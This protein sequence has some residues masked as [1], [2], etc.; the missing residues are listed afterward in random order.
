MKYKFL[1]DLTS[2]VLFEA[3]GKDLKEV[4]ENSALAMLTIIC[5]VK[6]IEK[7][8]KIEIEVSGRDEKDLL[9]NWLQELI[10]QVDIEEMFFSGFNILKITNTNLKAEIYGES[11]TPEKGETLVKAVTNYKFNL[12]KTEK[13]YKSTISLDI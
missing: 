9:Y 12:E 1:D 2:D 7:K 10:A 13:G 6:N 11:I 5:D 8:S 4:F 3:Y